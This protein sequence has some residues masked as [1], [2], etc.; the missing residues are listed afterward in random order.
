M[1][2]FGRIVAAAAVTG[3][4]VWS[5]VAFAD[6]VAFKPSDA[7]EAF[8]AASEFDASFRRQWLDCAKPFGLE[9][10]Q[11]RNATLIAR[12]EETAL[13]IREYLACEIDRIDDL[14]ARLPGSTVIGGTLCRYAH[15]S[16]GTIII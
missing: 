3:G 7:R 6:S 16:A 8:A 12:L 15:V 10:I 4:A 13:R 14:E 9:R 5:C 2:F 1:S 11:S